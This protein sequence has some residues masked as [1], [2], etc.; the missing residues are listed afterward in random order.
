MSPLAFMDDTNVLL[1]PS[2]V[3][4]FLKRMAKIGKPVGIVISKDK[5]K[6]LTNTVGISILPL[7]LPAITQRSLAEAI[8]TFTTGEAN[9]GLR[10][11]WG[12]L[13]VATPSSESTSTFS[14]P[15]SPLTPP[16]CAKYYLTRKRS[17]K[18]IANA[19]SP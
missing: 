15:N 7:L 12:S 3:N 6:I 11:L 16:P 19:S 1:E 10:I 13:L 5:T 8:S 18:Y 17:P 2:E 9:R 14:Q 4:W